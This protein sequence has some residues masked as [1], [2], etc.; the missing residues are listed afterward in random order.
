MIS[1]DCRDEVG[2]GAQMIIALA[3][4]VTILHKWALMNFSVLP[5]CASCLGGQYCL[6]LIYHRGTENT[7]VA[8]SK[9]ELEYF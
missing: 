3:L 1:S 9:Q 8:Q 5:L 7:E 2:A 4:N 6:T